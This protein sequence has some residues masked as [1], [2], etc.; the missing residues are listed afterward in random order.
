MN[1]KA[2]CLSTEATSKIIILEFFTHCC[3]NC[4]HSIN[5]LRQILAELKTER[6]QRL[7]QGGS[8][9]ACC[10]FKLISIHSPKFSREQDSESL[11]A[12]VE[13]M[14][15]LHS[16]VVNDPNRTLWQNL[17]IFCWPTILV[18]GPNPSPKPN[19]FNLI[20]SLIGEGHGRELK[21]LLDISAQYLYEVLDLDCELLPAVEQ[22]STGQ[23]KPTSKRTN[24]L[25]YPGIINYSYLLIWQ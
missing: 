21:T 22:L 10:H 6:N 12:F 18:F 19:E 9:V 20:F 24:S 5:E 4:V 1:T 2:P 17:G 16:A 15:M 3:I 8:H 13:K 7:N 25:Y 14:S 11:R 23:P